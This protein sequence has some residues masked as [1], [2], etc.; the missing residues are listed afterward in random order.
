[1]LKQYNIRLDC[2]SVKKLDKMDGT[3]SE[4]IRSAISLYI[5][6]GSSDVYSGGT[7]YIQHLEG[8][9]CFL[10]DQVNALTIAK[11]PLLAKI[12]MMLLD[13]GS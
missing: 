7:N 12:K 3:R 6:N 13:R 4:N 5:R 11:I 2:S 1:M 8:E 10:R 9:I